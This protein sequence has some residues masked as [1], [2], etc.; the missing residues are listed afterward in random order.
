MAD[1]LI[2]ETKLPN[3]AVLQQNGGYKVGSYKKKGFVAAILFKYQKEIKQ[4]K[5]SKNFPEFPKISKHN[6]SFL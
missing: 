3:Y 1:L 4:S 6:S 5:I 2:E